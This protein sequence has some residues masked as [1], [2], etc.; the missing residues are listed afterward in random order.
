MAA[1]PK[2]LEVVLVRLLANSAASGRVTLDEVGEAIGVV[3]VSTDDV[4]AL[5]TA[6]EEAG[7]EVAGPEGA[8]GVKN[9]QR[10]IP[11]ARALAVSLGRAPTLVELAAQTGLSEDDVR[12]ALALGRVLGR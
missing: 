6:L 8:R 11:A 7:R 9:L 2:K 12:H 4:D 5:L 3:P 1:L 10:V